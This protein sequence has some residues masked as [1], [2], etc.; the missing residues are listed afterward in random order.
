MMVH[1]GLGAY[2]GDACY[3]ESRFSWLPYWLDNVKEQACIVATAMTTAKP[4]S[5]GSS[6]IPPPAPK[7]PQTLE[8][9]QSWTPEDIYKAQTGQWAQWKEANRKFIAYEGVTA[10]EFEGENAPRSDLAQWWEKNKWFVLG[11]GMG[12]LAVAQ[13]TKR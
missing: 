6:L 11:A 12:V 1:T 9:L 5:S 7:A 10:M 8:Q 3:D 4:G 13:I 2:P